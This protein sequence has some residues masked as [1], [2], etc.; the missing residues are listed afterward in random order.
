MDGD[1]IEVTSHIYLPRYNM[2]RPE[3]QKIT[4][5]LINE[6]TGQ[7]IPVQT[8]PAE[9]SFLTEEFGTVS[10]EATGT[11]ARY[12]YDYAGFTFYIGKEMLDCDNR[13]NT[14]KYTAIV[15]YEDRIFQGTQ[16]L[17]GA[18]GTKKTEY[19]TACIKG[20]GADIGVTFGAQNELQI[21]VKKTE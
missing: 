21:I 12:N 6:E 1:K 11:V 4:V 10:D 14:T 3:D 15:E 2:S 8:Q 5:F 13:Y 17:K 16:I 7:K 18:D 9:A 19:K 20:N